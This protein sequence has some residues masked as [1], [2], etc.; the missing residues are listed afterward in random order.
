MCQPNA[1]SPAKPAKSYRAIT[2]RGLTADQLTRLKER[3]RNVD[4]SMEAYV[5]GLITEDDKQ[6]AII[7]LIDTLRMNATANRVHPD[8][9]SES[10]AVAKAYNIIADKLSKLLEI[11]DGQEAKA[12]EG[13]T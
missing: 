6:H 8:R 1:V 5:R 2:V 10:L 13:T 3:A 11:D 12:E 7:D 4:V 9:T